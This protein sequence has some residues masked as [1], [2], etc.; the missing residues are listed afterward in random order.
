MSLLE[1]KVVAG[2]LIAAYAIQYK[3]D[4]AKLSGLRLNALGF[5]ACGMSVSQERDVFHAPILFVDCAES[6]SAGFTIVPSENERS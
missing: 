1:N 5:V 6:G 2:I 4:T 3:I